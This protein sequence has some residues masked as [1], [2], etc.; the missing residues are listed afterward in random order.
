MRL[1][2][3]TNLFKIANLHLLSWIFNIKKILY[4]IIVS[5]TY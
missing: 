4:I 5:K 3:G 2:F 1:G